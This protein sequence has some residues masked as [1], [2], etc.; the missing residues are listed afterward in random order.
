[1]NSCVGGVPART[2][3]PVMIPLPAVGFTSAETEDGCEP[4]SHPA[5]R[6]GSRNKRHNRIFQKAAHRV[7]VRSNMS[8]VSKIGR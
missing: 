8:I 2:T 1:M 3:L 6:A 7:Q 5:S 4:R